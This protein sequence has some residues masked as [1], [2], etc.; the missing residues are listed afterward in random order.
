MVKMNKLQDSLIESEIRLKCIEEQYDFIK[1]Q[2]DFIKSKYDNEK[3]KI[4]DIKKQIN[5]IN[6]DRINDYIIKGKYEVVVGPISWPSDNVIN[7]VPSTTVNF[8]L[9]LTTSF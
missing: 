6:T 1:S 3:D 2:Y 8:Q 7:I 5:K 4:K 9:S